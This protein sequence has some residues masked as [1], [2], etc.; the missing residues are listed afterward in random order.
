M[1]ANTTN[2]VAPTT[3]SGFPPEP[4]EAHQ[5]AEGFYEITEGVAN[6]GLYG[7]SATYSPEDNKLRLY[8][9]RRLDD[10]TYARVKDAG[11]KWAPSQELFVAPMWTPA[12]ADLLVELCGE[13]GDEDKSLVERAEERAERFGEYRDNRMQ[14]ANNA[15]ASVD[16][17]TEHI[18]FGQP[19]LIGH[20]SERRAR[21]HAEKIE[22]GMRKSVQMWDTAQY[23]KQRAAGAL[24]HA[25]YK[26]DAGVRHR[27]IKGLQA[28]L[29]KAQKTIKESETL[30]KLWS[31]D[32]LTLDHAKG[33]A[34]RDRLSACCALLEAP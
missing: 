13:I 10:A 30:V 17:I 18:P 3:D 29:R 26:A 6:E 8:Y 28:D 1:N 4:S 16:A 21:K 20:H 32:G 2:T 25:K 22:Q 5:R 34:G 11:F 23:W 9:T 7:L 24:R 19:I 12:R 33:I 27:R 15:R 31:L 14:D